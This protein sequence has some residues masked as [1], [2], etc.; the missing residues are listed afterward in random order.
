MNVDDLMNNP[1]ILAALKEE[2]QEQKEKQ[3]R[4]ACTPLGFDVGKKV[5]GY[6]LTGVCQEGTENGISE[7]WYAVDDKEREFVIKRPSMED[8]GNLEELVPFFSWEA[9]LYS[10]LEHRNIAQCHDVF[11]LQ[12]PDLP[13]IDI[14]H[15]VIERLEMGADDFIQDVLILKSKSTINEE[16][17]HR[18]YVV[19][20]QAADGLS[21]MHS[22]GLVHCDFNPSQLMLD[23]HG[24]VKLMDLSSAKESGELIAGEQDMMITPQ[25]FPKDD[26]GN[27]GYLERPYVDP[28]QDLYAFGMSVMEMLLPVTGMDRKEIAH[29]MAHVPNSKLFARIREKNVVPEYLLSGVIGNCFESVQIGQP[30]EFTTER[31][32]EAVRSFAL[33]RYMSNTPVIIKDALSGEVKRVVRPAQD[34]K[35]KP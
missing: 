25:Y 33:T 5:E 7:L 8:L 34:Y 2:E 10:E 21:Y 12:H 35:K 9:R 14:P 16:Y 4:L 15:I 1:I 17:L 6:T 23:R 3:T 22:Q 13:L 31:L 27:L 20:S 32:Q 28:S 19:M 24:N 29:A 26:D 18:L 30:I 11:G